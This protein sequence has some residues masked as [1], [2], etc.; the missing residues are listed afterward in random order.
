MKKLDR[1]GWAEGMR[2]YTYGVHTGVR[3]STVGMLSQI[4]QLLPPGWKNSR[5]ATMQRLYSL[6]VAERFVATALTLLSKAINPSS[7]PPP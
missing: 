2:V 6:V 1:L 5:R 3:V 7:I 4:S